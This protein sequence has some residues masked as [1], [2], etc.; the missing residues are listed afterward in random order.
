MKTQAAIDLGHRRLRAVE[1]SVERG[2]ATVVR[3]VDVAIPAEASEG[4]AAALGA[5][6]AAA[7]RDAG[8]RVD[9]ATW[10][11]SRDRV[12]FK[13]IALPAA[14]AH[15]L[16]GM[17]RLAMLR[18]AAVGADA[19]IDFAL[20]G[21]DGT[22]CWAVAVPAAE[23][24]AIRSVAEAAGIAV[25]RVAPRTCGTAHLLA[26][27]ATDGAS[28]A[29]VDLAGDSAELVV[30]AASGLR[31]TRGASIAEESLEASATE[32]RR[33][34]TGFRLQQPDEHPASALV[35]G[36]AE[37]ASAVAHALGAGL[38]VPTSALASH[39]AVRCDV[40]P[41]TA[42]PLVGLLLEAPRSATRIDLASP[43]RTPDLAARR[44]M[45]A[46]AAVAVVALA[47]SV[48]WT[49]GK[50]E[51]SSLEARRAD[52]REKAEG[53]LAE[54][55]EFKRDELRA[56]H[57]DAWAA[58]QPSWLD[59]MLY[60]TSFAPD[61]SR[62]VLAGW[63]GQ[64]TGDEV[65]LAKDGSM[66][67]PAGARIAIDAEAADRSTAD[68]LREALVS[69]RDFTVRSTSTEGKAGRRLPVAVEL[70]IDSPDGPPVEQPAKASV[71]R[72]GGTR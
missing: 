39:P 11:V 8:L 64:S 48:G 5:F 16:P 38:G 65:E 32:A 59:S 54:H 7:L 68:A 47:Y 63:N 55:R 22:D 10:T 28:I 67:V 26:S 66:R 72:R 41:G 40:D 1:A 30:A 6:V 42:W 71:S 35:L 27:L 60:L 57:L 3:A 58:A 19:A 61:P 51:R 46:Y 34:W 4:G 45:R 12:A 62:V 53:A 15:E 37:M 44:R 70:V 9:R 31:A 56:R 43:R 24:D 14:E 18:E 36:A 29:A 33:S 23:M 17:V 50:K 21:Q 25:D 52:L 69:K 2:R 13:R 49:V 20:G